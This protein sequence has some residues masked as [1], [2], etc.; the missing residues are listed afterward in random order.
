MAHRGLE[1]IEQTVVPVEGLNGTVFIVGGFNALVE[2]GQ[3][4]AHPVPVKTNGKDVPKDHNE[5]QTYHER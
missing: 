2:R 3:R 1:L 5:T 4:N